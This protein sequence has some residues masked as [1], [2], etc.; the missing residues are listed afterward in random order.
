MSP[1]YVRIVVVELD[2]GKVEYMYSPLS[3]LEA[4]ECALTARGF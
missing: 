1:L 3:H 4:F 2:D